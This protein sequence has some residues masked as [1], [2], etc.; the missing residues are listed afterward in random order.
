M[1]REP[2]A[3]ENGAEPKQ[4]ELEADDR[5]GQPAAPEALGREPE[6]REHQAHT[7]Q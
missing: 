4:R 5:R 6:C 2:D 3:G 7:E 1:P